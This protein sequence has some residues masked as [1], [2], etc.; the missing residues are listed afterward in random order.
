[1]VCG[2]CNKTIAPGDRCIVYT[3]DKITGEFDETFALGK[4]AEGK[5][6]IWVSCLDPDCRQKTVIKL[7]GY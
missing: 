1:M 2:E 6:G 5:L 7:G 4:N 3:K